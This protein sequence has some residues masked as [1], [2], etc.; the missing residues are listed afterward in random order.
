VLEIISGVGHLSRATANV[1]RVFEMLS[2]PTDDVGNEEPPVAMTG[3][4]EYRNVCFSYGPDS[5]PVLHNVSLAIQP[6][7][8]VAVIGPSGSGKTTLVSLLPRF[9]KPSSGEILIDGHPSDSLPIPELRGLFG[10]VFQ[11]VFLFNTSIYENLR[12]ARPDASLEEVKEACR[13]TGAHDFIQRLPQGYYTKIGGTGSVLSR[14]ERQRITLARALIRNPKVLIIDEATASIDNTA[15]SEIIRSILQRM[16]GRTVIMVTHDIEL[17]NLVQR[18]IC[19]EEGTVAYDGVPQISRPADSLAGTGT[20][21]GMTPTIRIEQIPSAAERSHAHLSKILKTGLGP[22]AGMLLLPLLFSGG[23]VSSTKTERA[24]EVNQPRVAGG[25]IVEADDPNQLKKIGEALDKI[26]LNPPSK[27]APS[28][29]NVPPAAP[30]DQKKTP[31]PPK[32]STAQA[33]GMAGTQGQSADTARLISLPKLSSVEINELCDRLELKLRTELNYRPAASLV[34]DALPAPPEGL[35]EDKVLTRSGEGG[36]HVLRLGIRQFVS[37]PPQCWV[38]G[39]ILGDKGAMTPNPDLAKVEPA[40]TEMIAAMNQMRTGLTV[41]DLETKLIQLSYVNVDTALV[42]LQAMGMTTIAKPADVPQAVDFAKLPYVIM[43]PDPVAADVGLIGAKTNAQESQWGLSL[44][45]GVASDITANAV[46]SP[47]TQLMVMFHPAHPEQFSRVRQAL[48]TYIDRPARQIFI[49]GMVLEI[50]EDGL[51]DLGVSWDLSQGPLTITTTGALSAGSSIDTLSVFTPDTSKLNEIFDHPQFQWDWAVKLRALIQSGKAEVLSRPSVL[52]LDNRQST[53]R[54]GQD[55]P[56]ASSYEGVYSSSNKV[57][58]TF[59]YLPTGILLNIRPRINEAATE[60]SML[61]DTVV[62][63]KVPNA[64]L[65]LKSSDGTI[66]AS[67]PTVSTRRVQT[68]GRIRNNTPFIIGGLVAR[69][70]TVTMNKIPFLGDLPVIGAAF[71]AERNEMA[72]TEVI[73]VL[74]PYVLPEKELVPRLLPKDEDLFDNF[75]N[76]LF[77]DSYRIRAEDVFD[78]TFLLENPRIV[79]YRALAKQAVEK[80]FRLARSEPFRSF[81]RDSVPGEPILVARMIYEVVKR[82]NLA[83]PVRTPRIIYLEGQQVGGYNV[84]FLESLLKDETGEPFKDLGD[85]ALAI[86]FHRNIDSNDQERLGREP[87]PEIRVI[88][89]PNREA[90]NQKLWE[91]NQPK[92]GRENYAILIQNESDMLRLRRALVLKK[93]V[94]LNGGIDQMRLANFSLG[95]V[96]LMPELKADQIHL[97]DTDAAMFFFYTEHYYAA[98]LARI[99]TQLKELD[100]KLRLPEIRTLLETPNP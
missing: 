54:V 41:R 82:L 38:Q 79:N 76:K 87:I 81:V 22:V 53:I 74:T 66:L 13:I 48:D 98:T 30:T 28:G 99:E 31:E 94:V 96:L 51:K 73:I 21:M 69:E 45:P 3:H 33:A 4:I 23:C 37:Q 56:I 86:I 55:I 71:R 64:D 40:V 67:A 18:M 92:E 32:I 34:S 88:D 36:T 50:S 39:L 6:G 47:M 43:M 17:L 68:Y 84:D 20:S 44:T 2:E 72:K 5:T 89:C 63:A 52:T 15:A 78:L 24:V 14:G 26:A 25:A 90:W 16:E 12:Y 97:I 58:F 35:T 27:P 42:L 62:S 49:E 95:K 61:I 65:T 59:K 83:E 9:N 10:I 29:P 80:D 8:H 91:L 85:K 60:V 1:D 75:G 46:A 57:N 7:E 100:E 77:R 11:E 70:Q 93:I 19:I